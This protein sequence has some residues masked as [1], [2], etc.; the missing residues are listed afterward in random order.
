MRM[1]L[2]CGDGLPVSGLLTVFR[3]VVD[4]ADA[5]GLLSTPIPADLGYSWRPDKP[6]F[7]PR[8][9]AS[10]VSPPW[11]DVT[12]AA[13]LGDDAGVAEELT[14]I[15]VAVA[16]AEQLSTAERV[17][18]RERIDVL[19]GPYERHFLDWWERHDV[20][21][22]CAVN[23]TLSDAVPVTLALHRAAER[24]W[25]TGRPGGVLFWDHDL[26]GSY[27][28]HE[29]SSRV[30]PQAPNEFTPVPNDPRLHRWAVVSPALVEEGAGYPTGLQ[31]ELVPNVLPVVP[32][33]TS[34]RHREFLAQ[35]GLTDGR[36]VVLCPVRMFRVKGVEVAVRLL[37][38]VRDVCVGRDEPVPYLLV[39]GSLGED[40]EYTE[41]VMAA[42]AAE[43]V[44]DDVRFLDGVPLTS[45]RGPDGRWLLDEADLLR[46]CADSHGGVFFT[47]NR[48]DVESVGLGP[49][50]AALV[51]VPCAS[52][53]YDARDE[54]YG[55]E[56]VQV[57]VDPQAPAASAA[58]FA[59]YLAAA[60]R[61][62]PAV[63]L[64]LA[65]N[66]SSVR[67]RFPDGPWRDLL[68]QMA[69]A[70][71]AGRRAPSATTRRL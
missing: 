48:P 22:V 26:F 68:D 43:G 14:A 55:S 61:A 36:P 28:V 44:G 49:A 29:G 9:A 23:M 41:E 47:P 12:D 33:E 39:F 57:R 42:V 51:D 27:A 32:A 59:D 11:L 8:G 24:R 5:A 31:P 37:A 40:P 60:R 18:L 21:W 50:L 3:N 15:R 52:T 53:T 58:E 35:H 70:V 1:A 25:G 46:V 63:Q 30:Y 4:R 7:Y 17:R 16:A 45:G 71:T 38:A 13:P 66:R 6:E 10:T 2:V 54:V 20:D 34:T 56:F 64:M 19:A 69:R 65:G 62:D 67:E